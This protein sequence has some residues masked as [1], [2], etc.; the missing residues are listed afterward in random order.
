MKLTRRQLRRLIEATVIRKDGVAIP[1]EDPIED[2]MKDLDFNPDQKDKLKTLA[3]S[4]DHETRVQSDSLA[5]MVDFKPS[6]RFGV[7][8]FS[9]QVR[10]T[11]A[12]I[13]NLM[14]VTELYNIIKDS[15]DYWIHEHMDSLT[16]DAL[17]TE[18]YT[19]Y[20]KK[21]V[22]TETGGKGKSDIDFIKETVYDI[23]SQYLLRTGDEN[24]AKIMGLF[25]P[26]E[27]SIRLIDELVYDILTVGG[28]LYFLYRDWRKYY[29]SGMDDIPYQKQSPE[30]KAKIANI[31]E[32]RR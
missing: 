26:G 4:S 24:Y 7:D 23:A 13:N 6:D 16:S 9:D 5:D 19:T 31:K 32:G 14:K 25:E 12:D 22:V 15:C 27:G 21:V 18:N 10:L 29:L 17:N 11:E 28:S 8:T 30:L 2:P 3:L 20:V 1:I